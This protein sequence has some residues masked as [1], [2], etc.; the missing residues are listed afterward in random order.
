MNKTE[1]KRTSIDKF[2]YK[3]DTAEEIDV[4]IVFLDLTGTITKF[5][6]C[7][8]GCGFVNNWRGQTPKFKI[9]ASIELFSM[10]SVIVSYFTQE[11]N[12]NV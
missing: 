1:T 7:L 5:W 8:W 10:G 2:S 6:E 9:C 11:N 4:K 3:V 12:G